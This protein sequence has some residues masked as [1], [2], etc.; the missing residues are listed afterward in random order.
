RAWRAVED[1]VRA[2]APRALVVRP[3]PLLGSP[4]IPLDAPRDG[5]PAVAP[6]FAPDVANVALDLL[7]DGENGIWHLAN[8]GLAGVGPRASL[9]RSCVLGTSR[10]V[11]LPS[12]DDAL[13]RAAEIPRLVTPDLSRRSEDDVDE[14]SA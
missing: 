9:R 7:I 12:L 6:A 13:A 11:L 10:A 3:G 1:A 14:A 8:A 5:T 2:A 4:L